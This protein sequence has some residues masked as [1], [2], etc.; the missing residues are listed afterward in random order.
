M[1]DSF[2]PLLKCTVDI[3]KICSL[4]TNV[5]KRKKVTCEFFGLIQK[6]ILILINSR[7]TGM[8]V[9]ILSDF[10]IFEKREA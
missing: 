4:S 10:F 1:V 2:I 8:L 9:L 5:L 6:G 7:R 3:H